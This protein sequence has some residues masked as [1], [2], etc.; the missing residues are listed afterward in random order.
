MLAQL[1]HR[2]VPGL[3]CLHSK[4]QSSKPPPRVWRKRSSAC[5]EASAVAQKAA[6]KLVKSTSACC[7]TPETAWRSVRHCTG[8]LNRQRAE[9]ALEEAAAVL[10]WQKIIPSTTTRLAVSLGGT[11]TR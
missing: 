3:F 9:L 11:P 6:S 2:G 5:R 7:K 10:P 1:F 4:L 8:A